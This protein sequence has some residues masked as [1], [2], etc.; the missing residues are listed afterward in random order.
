[1]AKGIDTRTETEKRRDVLHKRICN[2]YISIIQSRS[3]KMTPN[4]A[5]GIIAKKEGM[6]IMGVKGIIIKYKLYTPKSKNR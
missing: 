1:M 3:P 4:R 2:A 6:T 5:F